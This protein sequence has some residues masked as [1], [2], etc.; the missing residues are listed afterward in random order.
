MISLYI[1]ISVLVLC[2]LVVGVL[3]G[4]ALA[5]WADKPDWQRIARKTCYAR[6]PIVVRVLEPPD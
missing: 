4:I 3:L 2:A 5:A 1:G 6:A